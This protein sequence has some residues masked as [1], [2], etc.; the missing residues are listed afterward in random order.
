MNAPETSV[1]IIASSTSSTRQRIQRLGRVLRPAKNKTEAT[2]FTIYISDQEKNRLLE[3][4]KELNE[5][6][7]I[8][9]L[10][11]ATDHG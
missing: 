9:W 8:N 2:I 11:G 10:K 6:I 1:A 4:Y 3:E 5:K 7:E